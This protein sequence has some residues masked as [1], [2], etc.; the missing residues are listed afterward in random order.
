MKITFAIVIGIALVF[1][2]SGAAEK[3]DSAPPATTVVVASGVGVDADKAL[4]NALRNAV[5]QSVGLIVDAETVVKN[6]SVIKEQILTYSDGFVEKF[7]R[8][9]EIKREDGLYDVKIKAVVKRR[10]LIEKLKE[11]K[12]ASAKVEGESLFAEVVT[13]LDAEKSAARLLEKAMEGLPASLLVAKVTNQKPQILKKNDTGADVMWDI[14]VGFDYKEYKD[15]VLPKLQ[16][17]LND[18]SLRKSDGEIVNNLKQDAKSVY[19]SEG[20]SPKLMHHTTLSQKSEFWPD[21]EDLVVSDVIGQ[22]NPRRNNATELC[23]Y[24]NTGKNEKGDARRWRWFI[25][26]KATT[27]PV[28]VSV[29]ARN[30]VLTVELLGADGQVIREDK[31]RFDD[32]SGR[33]PIVFKLNDARWPEAGLDNAQVK[34]PWFC[35]E[36]IRNAPWTDIKIGPYIIINSDDTN[37]DGRNLRYGQT[38]D[39]LHK[40]QLTL[41]EMKNIHE[42]R[43]SVTNG[44]SRRR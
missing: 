40:V 41:E 11:A 32:E 29:M 2:H 16:Q 22:R 38:M 5:E 36:C 15:K 19:P 26:D 23:V 37:G 9:K 28:L 8:V 42:I 7:E 39:Y 1:L 18:T 20:P 34:L 17:I 12:I 14:E 21:V 25:C 43:C 31:I 13:Q 4:R 27:G 44:E 24:L 6:E 10:Q 30:P 35:R 3:T 33:I